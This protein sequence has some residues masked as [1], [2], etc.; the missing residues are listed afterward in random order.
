ME[1]KK[2]NINNLTISSAKIWISPVSQ[3]PSIFSQASKGKWVQSNFEASHRF[4]LSVLPTN[5]NLKQILL[6]PKMILL[7]ANEG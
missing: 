6:L 2:Q 1:L 3:M 4:W 5:E 7:W